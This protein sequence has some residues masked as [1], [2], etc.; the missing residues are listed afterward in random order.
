VSRASLDG[1][2]ITPSLVSATD[3]WGVAV[4]ALPLPPA[5]PDTDPPETSI[6]KAPANKTKKPKAKYKFT[7]DEPGSTFQCKLKGKGLRK[8]VKNFRV[9][10]SP[11][12]YK[13]LR[14]GKFKFQVRAIDAAGNVDPSPAKD[15][16]KVV[17]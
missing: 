2:A 16:F 14:D 9:C 15:G 11:R 5:P 1:T 7:A 17:S 6:T 12:K 10:G 3:P 8:P 4:D 13:R